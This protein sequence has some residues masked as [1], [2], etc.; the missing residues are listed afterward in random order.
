MSDIRFHILLVEDDIAMQRLT[1]RILEREGCTVEIANNGLGALEALKRD[2]F[3]L[4]LM[5]VQMP[6]M[7]GLETT[8]I[9]R[10]G[11]GGS[12]FPDIP[13]IGVT[14]F[15]A[16]EIKEEC[17][18]AGMNGFMR[19]PFQMDNFL[20]EV[21]ALVSDGICFFPGLNQ[22]EY[23]D[24]KPIKP[25]V[26]AGGTETI[27]IAEDDKANRTFLTTILS[28]FRYKTLVAEDGEEAVSEFMKHKNNI[29]LL[30]TDIMMP[31]KNGIDAYN[32]MKKIRPDI[33]ALFLSAYCEETINQ[34]GIIHEG[35]NFLFKPLNPEKFLRKV[36][37][38]LD[39]DL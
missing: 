37:E 23:S 25:P 15:S 16:E 32:E 12:I 38:I 39:G 21:E 6:E 28:E 27:L 9:I 35:I 8:M 26:V 31:K 13:I 34:Q 29:H 20:R 4:V 19:K 5:D 17:L 2:T 10:N 14:S 30:I 11:N 24:T 36:R 33:K 3:D 7:C 18:T 1:S 22:D